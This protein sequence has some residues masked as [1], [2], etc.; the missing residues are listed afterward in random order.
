V[1]RWTAQTALDLVRLELLRLSKERSK[2]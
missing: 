2:S 1:K